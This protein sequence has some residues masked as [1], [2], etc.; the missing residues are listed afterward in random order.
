MTGKQA[1]IKSRMSVSEVAG[2][3][4]TGTIVDALIMQCGGE[5]VDADSTGNHALSL[6]PLFS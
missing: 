3:F 4:D 1:Q 6:S 2:R 5:V